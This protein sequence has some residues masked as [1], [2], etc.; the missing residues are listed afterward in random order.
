MRFRVIL[1]LYSTRGVEIRDK[2]N[3]GQ[4]GQVFSLKHF[5][6][7]LSIPGCGPSVAGGLQIL[8]LQPKCYPANVTLGIL[9]CSFCF[10]FEGCAPMSQVLHEC[11]W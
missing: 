3:P 10:A 6:S 8:V 1:I 9:L 7:F 2:F 11:L 4:G 5:L